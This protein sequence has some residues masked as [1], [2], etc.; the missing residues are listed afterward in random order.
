M[1][2]RVEQSV[3]VVS[4]GRSLVESV[5]AAARVVHV[6]VAQRRGEEG[7]EEAEDPQ[8]RRIPHLLP[9]AT[10]FFSFLLTIKEGARRRKC[11][12]NKDKRSYKTSCQFR[13]HPPIRKR[14]AFQ[15][16]VFA[17]ISTFFTK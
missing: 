14:W 5:V 4:V 3:C 10:S 7:A 16:R 15:Q 6:R 12:K 1:Y 2:L 17:V 9:H 8:T 13:W 11:D